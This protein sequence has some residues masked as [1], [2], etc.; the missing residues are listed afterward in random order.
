MTRFLGFAWLVLIG[1]MVLPAVWQLWRRRVPVG[2][3]LLFLAL[4]TLVL[5]L[6]S[7]EVG[8]AFYWPQGSFAYMP[9]IAALAFATLWIVGHDGDGPAIGIAV[10]VA[11]VVAAFSNEM[12]AMVVFAFS[13]SFLVFV[14]ATNRRN[15]DERSFLR[16]CGLLAA[17]IVASLSVFGFIVRGRLRITNENV[18]GADTHDL[19]GSLV[20]ALLRFPQEVTGWTGEGRDAVWITGMFMARIAL[21]VGALALFRT[22]ATRSRIRLLEA[23]ALVAGLFGG[24]FASLLASYYQF[25]APCCQRHST[26]RE[27]LFVLGILALAR[28]ASL[29]LPARMGD[30]AGRGSVTLV[31]LLAATML[32]TTPNAAR[33]RADYADYDRALAARAA[34]WASGSD[35]GRTMVFTQPPKLQIVGGQE[36]PPGL[37]E[38]GE[39]TNWIVRI[40]MDFFRK[41]VVDMRPAGAG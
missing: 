34:T 32:A 21:F 28:V 11:L 24:A 15:R 29:L 35:T 33:L 27:C 26:M 22:L 19:A 5:F 4:T 25:G 23:L 30:G 13:V 18:A 9:A 14:V 17:P 31:A 38:R 1:A 40:I 41:D 3:P 39:N 8:E 10:P 2:L 36:W 12:G 6:N 37:H 16:I 7:Q 20:Q